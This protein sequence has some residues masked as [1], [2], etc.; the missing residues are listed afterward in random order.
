[1]S[2][3]GKTVLKAMARSVIER[4][5]FSNA[6]N[7]PVGTTSE[8]VGWNVDNKSL[9]E[10]VRNVRPLRLGKGQSSDRQCQVG[11]EGCTTNSTLWVLGGARWRWGW[12]MTL[13]ID[14]DD[15]DDGK[16]GACREKSAQGTTGP[17][18]RK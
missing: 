11:F 2:V 17:P 5:V 1:M 13:W 14:D 15:D 10:N 16:N 9:G 7:S 6:S 3:Q 8:R 4:R 12:M 18:H